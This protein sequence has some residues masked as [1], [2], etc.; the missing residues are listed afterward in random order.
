[1]TVFRTRPTRIKRRVTKDTGTKS[2]VHLRNV[3]DEPLVI[4][5][6]FTILNKM[7]DLWLRK[8][9]IFTHVNGDDVRRDVQSSTDVNNTQRFVR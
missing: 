6:V 5:S 3:I 1:M 8:W 2:G 9:S 7:N 4:Q